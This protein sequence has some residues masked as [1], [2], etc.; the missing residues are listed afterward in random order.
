MTVKT[1]RVLWDGSNAIR[2]DVFAVWCT[3]DTCSKSFKKWC[4]MNVG[5][6]AIKSSASDFISEAQKAIEIMNIGVDFL[7]AYLFDEMLYIDVE[8]NEAKIASVLSFRNNT[9]L[10]FEEIT[11]NN[12]QSM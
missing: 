12:L 6:D 11:F 7:D 4:S 5:K 1:I 9:N 8:T 3:D 10:W 2:K